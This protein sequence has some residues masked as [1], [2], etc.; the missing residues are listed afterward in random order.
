M[1]NLELKEFT[2]LLFRLE[3]KK[4]YNESKLDEVFLSYDKILYR[5]NIQ[6]IK[7]KTGKDIKH[8]D[9]R[10][11][12]QVMQR[13]HKNCRWKSEK[14]RSRNFYILIEGYYWLISVYFNN[15]KKLIDADIEFFEDL[16][17]QYE[18]LLKLESK[19]LFEKDMKIQE[20]VNY[21]NKKYETIEKAIWKMIKIHSNYRYVVNN[22]FVI[23]KEGVEWLCKNCFKQKYLELLESYKMDLTEKF[24]KAGYIYDNFFNKN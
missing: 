20:L 21:F 18:E 6:K 5:L 12:I 7:T 1:N 14:I 19:N 2:L 4:I 13:K 23:T 24:I 8:K 15:K 9:L 10:Y 16:I 17:K 11:A 22:E 3:E